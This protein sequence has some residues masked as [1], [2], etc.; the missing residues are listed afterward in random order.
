MSI[1]LR[2]KWNDNR[3]K[4]K[5]TIKPKAPHGRQVTV[6]FDQETFDEI[7]SLARKSNCSFAEQVR[8]LVTWGLLSLTA[9]DEVLLA[10]P[11]S[12]AGSARPAGAPR[13]EAVSGHKL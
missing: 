6:W 4:A 2:L 3:P 11:T 9:E 1:S 13:A 5:G 8:T 12:F 7:A 10:K